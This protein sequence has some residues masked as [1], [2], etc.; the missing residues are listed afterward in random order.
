MF[1]IGFA[2][3]S[4]ICFVVV[5]I[6]IAVMGSSIAREKSEGN[7]RLYQYWDD[8]DKNIK[9]YVVAMKDVAAAIREQRD[10]FCQQCGVYPCSCHDSV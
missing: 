7:K 4:G 5:L 2:A 1:W 6:G 10:P 9:Q 8:T 3:G